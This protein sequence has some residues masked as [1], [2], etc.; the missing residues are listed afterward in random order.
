MATPGAPLITLED[1]GAFRLEVRVDEA[2]AARSPSAQ[3]ADVRLGDTGR[4]RLDRAR[5]V[6]VARL[7]AA[8]HA[9]LVKLESADGAS[10][11]SG[12]FGRARFQRAD[13]PDADRARTARSSAAVS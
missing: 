10:I 3:T 13:A 9:F 7:D 11:R 2:R 5:I 4:R 6:E 12:P 8:S 1:T